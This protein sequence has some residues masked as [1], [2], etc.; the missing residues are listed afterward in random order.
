MWW[1]DKSPGVKIL[2]IWTFGT[3]AVLVTNVVR[4]RM[5]DMDQ[6]IKSQSQNQQQIPDATDSIITDQPSDSSFKGT[7]EDKL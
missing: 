6:M 1:K 4:T 3:A 5:R 7:S 2:W